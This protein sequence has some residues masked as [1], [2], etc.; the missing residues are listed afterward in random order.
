MPP[1]PLFVGFFISRMH[2]IFIF[3][4]FWNIT[5]SSQKNHRKY[6]SVVP[7]HTPGTVISFF[8]KKGHSQLSGTWTVGQGYWSNTIFL[9]VDLSHLVIFATLDRNHIEPMSDQDVSCNKKIYISMETWMLSTL[10]L[11]FP[12]HFHNKMPLLFNSVPENSWHLLLCT[13]S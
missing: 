9:G 3:R 7:S 10:P 12:Y 1:S 8:P 4:F 13:A 5:I 6:R 2:Q 11:A